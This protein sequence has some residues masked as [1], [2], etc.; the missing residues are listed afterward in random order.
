LFRY[1]GGRNTANRPA[2]VRHRVPAK[3]VVAILDRFPDAKFEDL[4]EIRDTDQAG[5]EQ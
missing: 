5:A 3:C 2:T 4:F 1:V